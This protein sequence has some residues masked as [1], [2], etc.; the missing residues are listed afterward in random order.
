MEKLT[1]KEIEEKLQAIQKENDPFLEEIKKDSRKGVQRLLARWKKNQEMK[2]QAEETFYEMCR[3][4]RRLREEGFSLIA[5]IDEAGRGPLVGPVVAA[6]VILPE[7]FDLIGVNDSKKLT[8]RQ[9]EEFYVKICEQA[10][11]VGVGIVDAKEIDRLNIYEATKKAML[12]AVNNLPVSPDFLLI[13]AVPLHTPYP[14]EAIVKGDSQSVS[15]AAAS[16]VAKVTRDRIMLELDKK[17]PQYQFA[18]NM[19]Y[20]TKEHLQAIKQYGITPYHRRS[21]APIKDFFT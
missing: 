17:F 15:I 9:R 4:E 16:I 12:T 18:K 19:G 6:A 11:A 5:G 8:A 10:V 7:T 3:H 1:I 20:G 13:D 2:K 21:F 14:S